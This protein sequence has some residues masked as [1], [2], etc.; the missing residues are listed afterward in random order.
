MSA[1]AVASAVVDLV[2]VDFN[3]QNLD[4]NLAMQM[5]KNQIEY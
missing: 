4:L 5:L 1:I 3:T 2:G